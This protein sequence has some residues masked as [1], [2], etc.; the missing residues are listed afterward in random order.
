MTP[1]R[2]GKRTKDITMRHPRDYGLIERL[3]SAF[4]LSPM[5]FQQ[6]MLSPISKEGDKKS[7]RL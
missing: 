2:F 4:S 7:T 1:L 3:L 6:P 5:A